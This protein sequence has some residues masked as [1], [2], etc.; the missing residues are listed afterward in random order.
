MQAQVSAWEKTADRRTIFL[1]CYMLMTGN[2]LKALEKGEFNDTRWV[3]ELLHRFADYY[4]TALEQYEQDYQSSPLVWQLA[5]NATQEP[6]K[7]VLQDLILGV[8]AH[9]NY[10]L[11]ITLV[12]MLE[13]EWGELSKDGLKERYTDHCHVNDIIGRTID[14][15]QDQIIEQTEPAMK[16]IDLALGPIDEWM[17]S[18]LIT[19]WREEVWQNALQMIETANPGER[20]Q[21]RQ[22]IE[23]N[24]L[25]R[26]K[27]ILFRDASGGISSLI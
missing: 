5:F 24:A 18:R 15:V 22:Q 2:M 23:V 8:N 3:S 26:G 13:P 27:A 4:F 25:E 10:D 14:T 16:F 7:L 19:H 6:G 12:D 20:E 1:S 17:T 21:K 9:I 11:V